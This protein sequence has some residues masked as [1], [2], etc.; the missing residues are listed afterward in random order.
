MSDEILA[1]DPEGYGDLFIDLADV[2]MENGH[3]ARALPLLKRCVEE[4]EQFSK[5]KIL[6][7]FLCFYELSL[8]SP[9][10]SAEFFPH[11][12]LKYRYLRFKCFAL[13]V[14][15]YFGDSTDSTSRLLCG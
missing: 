11:A 14:I 10:I 7:N 3:H 6:N 4:S 8:I 15:R 5:V 13:L 2:Y 12:I 1:H 9:C